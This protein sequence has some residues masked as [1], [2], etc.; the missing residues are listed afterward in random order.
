MKTC[1]MLLKLSVNVCQAQ[2][3]QETMCILCI[4]SKE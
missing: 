3:L 4:L 1:V 2:F